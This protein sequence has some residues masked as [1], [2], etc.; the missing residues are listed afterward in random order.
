MRKQAFAALA[1]A[2]MI[3]G[4][5]AG[6]ATADTTEL[7]VDVASPK[8]GT[9][10]QLGDEVPVDGEVGAGSVDPWNI[11]F[12]VDASGSTMDQAGDKTVYE[13]E[14]LGGKEL[15]KALQTEETDV[16]M[17]VVYFAD[18]AE[19]IELTTDMG[20]IDAELSR[21]YGDAER[22]SV[23]KGTICDAGLQKAGEVLKDAKGNKRIYF[24][25]D[26]HCTGSP[27]DTAKVL[28]DQ[29]IEIFPV[30]AGKAPMSARMMRSIPATASRS[31]ILPSCP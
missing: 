2:A 5:S 31:P 11:V 27:A 12:V 30:H 21:G 14:Q 26:G 18:T 22:P 20:K 13:Q 19:G 8:D 15:L 9:V 1:A 23:G 16:N 10:Y 29:G 17:S 24:L 4:G 3:V 6:I 28:K 25:T 7:F